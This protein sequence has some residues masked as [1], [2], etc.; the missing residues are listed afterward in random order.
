MLIC[1]LCYE[2]L[3][4]TNLV[5]VACNGVCPKI[6]N[7][8][9]VAYCLISCGVFTLRTPDV[10]ILNMPLHIT[11]NRN[12]LINQFNFFNLH[13]KII[14]EKNHLNQISFSHLNVSN[15]LIVNLFDKFK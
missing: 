6:M 12:F 3:S 8:K 14:H 11:Y 15:K 2:T 10:R 4:S 1:L 7:E 5:F 13:L 9:L